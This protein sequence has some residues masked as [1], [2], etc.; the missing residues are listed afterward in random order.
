MQPLPGGSV[1]PIPDRPLALFLDFDGT[2]VDFAETP[3]AVIPDPSLT[4]LL[5]ALHGV[6]HGAVAIVSGR[7]IASLD[8]LL[9]PLTL[10]TAGLHGLE[11]RTAT[12]RFHSAPTSPPWRVPMRVALEHFVSG[13]PGLLLEDKGTS[14]ALHY[15][16]APHH[17]AEV[18]SLM[19]SLVR[20]LATDATLI[21]GNAVVEVRPTGLDKASAVAAFLAEPPFAGRCPVYLGD[22]TT[23]R[24]AMRA[25]EDHGG[26]AIAV[27][28]QIEATWR[29][30]TPSHVR[31]WLTTL[32]AEHSPP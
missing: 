9:S 10:P 19:D 25:S 23:D 18:R 2:V 20:T 6:L 21:D 26:I 14:L 7:P 15:R 24:V 8:R 29:L 12:G 4:G 11:R 16:R 28:H 27:G 1:P 30:S 31:A 3:D 17:E 5:D 32:I 13:R 22:D